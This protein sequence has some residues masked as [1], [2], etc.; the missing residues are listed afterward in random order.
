MPFEFIDD[1]AT[2]DVAFKA[3][4]RTAEELFVA[5]SDAMLNVM[6][7][8][9][10][11]VKPRQQRQ[12]TVAAEDHEMLLFALLQELIFYKDAE[13]LLLRVPEVS[14]AADGELLR[15]SAVAEG[16][17]IDVR[18]HEMGVD[19]KAVTLHRYRVEESAQGWQAMVILD[20]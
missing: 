19:V 10:A 15:L 1:I 6:V 17:E 11:S 3:W 4:G 14:I 16:E 12:L 8:D 20:I 5:A 13:M 18:R 9:L 7:A 2:A